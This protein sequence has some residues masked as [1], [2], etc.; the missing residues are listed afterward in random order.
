MCFLQHL[1]R[2][3]LCFAAFIF[4]LSSKF[5]FVV[6][7]FLFNFRISHHFPTVGK[8]QSALNT[9]PQEQF[10]LRLLLKKMCLVLLEKKHLLHLVVGDAAVQPRVAVRLVSLTPVCLTELHVNSWIVQ[11][12]R[13]FLHGGK[14]RFMASDG[15]QSLKLRYCSTFQDIWL[16]QQFDSLVQR[17]GV[18]HSYSDSVFQ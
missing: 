15:I 13:Q 7:Y 18:W 11:L 9:Y 12:L 2:N 5:H 17:T 3:R 6:W 4:E 14:T 1:N 10:S 16:L 8:V